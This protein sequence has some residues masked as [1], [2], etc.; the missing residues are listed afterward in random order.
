MHIDTVYYTKYNNSSINSLSRFYRPQSRFCLSYSLTINNNQK[1]ANRHHL[2]KK[3]KPPARQ[4]SSIHHISSQPCCTATYDLTGTAVAA[5][6]KATGN[7]HNTVT[8]NT[9]HT[10]T[11]DAHQQR[12][13]LTTVVRIIC[14]KNRY[15]NNTHKRA[16]VH[17]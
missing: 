7:T 13:H 14:R 8:G 9:H 16:N 1:I 10:A 17:I 5:H 15:S 2:K 11:G 4:Y 3:Y 12:K 6:H